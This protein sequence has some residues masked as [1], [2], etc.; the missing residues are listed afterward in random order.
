MI[1]LLRP[2]ISV[3]AS[4]WHFIIIY[5]HIWQETFRMALRLF[6]KDNDYCSKQ[7]EGAVSPF[8]NISDKSLLFNEDKIKLYV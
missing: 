5:I 2:H 6:K 8:M 7:K 1:T 4:I 3:N